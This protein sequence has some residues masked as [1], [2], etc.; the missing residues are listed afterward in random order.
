M[1][2]STPRKTWKYLKEKSRRKTALK[3]MMIL[4]SIW[5]SGCATQIWE[6]YHDAKECEILINLIL[7]GYGLYFCLILFLFCL[8]FLSTC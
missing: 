1:L 6:D 8:F 5:R 2:T 4:Q 7:K 3:M